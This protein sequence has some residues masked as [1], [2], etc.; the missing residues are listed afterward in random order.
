M[1]RQSRRTSRS[2]NAR[3][4]YGVPQGRLR[5]RLA[6]PADSSNRHVGFAGATIDARMVTVSN[7]FWW[8]GR[9]VPACAVHNLCRNIKEART[10]GGSISERSAHILD[11]CGDSSFWGSSPA[12]W[13]PHRPC[14]E[15]GWGAISIAP[16]RFC[17]V[18][19]YWRASVLAS[20]RH[21][22]GWCAPDE[23][24]EGRKL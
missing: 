5:C 24:L 2:P 4:A 9:T 23:R 15:S 6:T 17:S 21:C 11:G 3:S 13:C 18:F 22:A 14:I 19:S 8:L 1:L 16:I 20:W 7:P 10:S 12:H